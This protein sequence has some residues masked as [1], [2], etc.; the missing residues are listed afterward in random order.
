MVLSREDEELPCFTRAG[1]LILDAATTSATAA[2]GVGAAGVSERGWCLG[3]EGDF[4]GSSTHTARGPRSSAVSRF[5]E[6]EGS[7]KKVG[8]IR[9]SEWVGG[10]CPT[11][12]YL[13]ILE[14]FPDRWK[15]NT[16]FT[17]GRCHFNAI[18]ARRYCCLQMHSGCLL[19][20]DTHQGQN[21]ASRIV[22]ALSH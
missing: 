2:P 12:Y 3:F 13:K 19:A 15:G 7:S 22:R 9:I 18:L 16:L 8:Q 6:E 5:Y 4:L 11:N 17:V 20:L 10:V 1:A 14:H 21:I